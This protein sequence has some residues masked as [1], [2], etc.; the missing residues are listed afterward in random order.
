L[1]ASQFSKPKG[2][3]KYTEEPNKNAPKQPWSNYTIDTLRRH[4]SAIRNLLT[5]NDHY[6]A[7]KY[8]V[9]EHV[10]DLRVSESLIWVDITLEN[11]RRNFLD[12][13]N[14]IISVEKSQHNIGDEY[15]KKIQELLDAWQD[16]EDNL[17]ELRI[18]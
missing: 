7:V 13:A 17:L 12:K 4:A 15:P 11:S 8:Q 16:L 6:S 18:S 3:T 10:R 1:V 14:F 9:A 5:N 2:D